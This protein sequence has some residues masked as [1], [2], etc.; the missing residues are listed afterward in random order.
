MLSELGWVHW[1]AL[2]LHIALL[3]GLPYRSQHL[4]LDWKSIQTSSPKLAKA[5]MSLV[6]SKG[7]HRSF[8]RCCLMGCPNWDGL[9]G[10]HCFCTSDSLSDLQQ[11]G[12]EWKSICPRTKRINGI[13]ILLIVVWNEKEKTMQFSNPFELRRSN[14]RS[15]LFF[16]F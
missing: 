9:T 16:E 10:V 4:G 7:W 1:A 5:S 13:T 6:R 12:L 2:L 3:I 11:L 14:R 8:G 15:Q